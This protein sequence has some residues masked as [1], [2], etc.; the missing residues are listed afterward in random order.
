MSAREVDEQIAKGLLTSAQQLDQAAAGLREIAS[1]VADPTKGLITAA[2]ERSQGA[3]AEDH[4]RTKRRMYYR[5]VE[6]AT[7]GL[8]TDGEQVKQWFLEQILGALGYPAEFVAH[9]PG[10]AP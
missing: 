7:A 8:T 1:L 9:E 3:A 5:V 6:L 10:V 2:V 4:A